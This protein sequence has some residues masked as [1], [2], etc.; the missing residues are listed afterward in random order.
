[1]NPDALMH[2]TDVLMEDVLDTAPEELFA[3]E[4]DDPTDWKK[5]SSRFD[6][7]LSKAKMDI[8]HSITEHGGTGRKFAHV[9]DATISAGLRKALFEEAS[10]D[11]GRRDGLGVK[12]LSTRWVWSSTRHRRT[13]CA[14][15]SQIRKRLDWVDLAFVTL[16]V[17][18]FIPVIYQWL[19]EPPGAAPKEESAHVA[20]IAVN[21]G[22]RA[23]S[24]LVRTPD[25]ATSSVVPSYYSSFREEM[26]LM[27]KAEAGKREVGAALAS[28]ASQERKVA[29]AALVIGNRDYEPDVD[30]VLRTTLNDARAVGEE[31]EKG[32]FHVEIAVNQ[33]RD[34]MQ[35]AIKAFNGKLQKGMTALIFFSGYGIQTNRRSYLIPIDADIW[36]EQEV[37][38]RGIGLDDI[39]AQMNETGADVKIAIIDAARR[40]PYE[41]RFRRGGGAQ[42]L[43]PV[44]APVG[45]LVLYSANAGS[46][47]G[48]VKES[49]VEHSLLV[50]E[51]LKE[52][53]GEGPS[54]GEV[55][56]RIRLGVSR[57]SSNEQTPSVLSS[58]SSTFSFHSCGKTVSPVAPPPVGDVPNPNP[59]VRVGPSLE[60]QRDFR[61]S[62]QS[63]SSD[64][65]LSPPRETPPVGS[66]T[67]ESTGTS[68]VP[69]R[70]TPIRV[71]ASSASA[72]MRE[73]RSLAD[74]HSRAKVAQGGGSASSDLGR[75]EA[76]A[77]THETWIIQVGG[78]DTEGAAQRRLLIAR[79]KVRYLLDKADPFT[80]PVM[81]GEKMLYR[82]RFAGFRDKEDAEEACRQ[83]KIKDVDCMTIS[84]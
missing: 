46:P 5:L 34:A 67:A 1:L 47:G 52:M 32:G 58:L 18:I 6:H 71:Q 61:P 59:Q 16:F 74:D 9:M 76:D 51:I 30:P 54:A 72:D 26:A 23:T 75:P 24:P 62:G 44:N 83:L 2:L 64:R 42:G 19:A 57:A 53:Q 73:G 78:F 68:I 40:N 79:S 37:Q 82:A 28:T 66:G 33:T 22:A 60:Q 45:S 11:D 12:L 80:E 25:R 27:R 43:A 39:L 17:A 65:L 10:N 49:G 84:Q 56:D 14:P 77:R 63:A 55:F 15:V 13:S 41:R 20:S 35:R 70:V 29:C 4:A 31:L 38:P 36:N 50:G 48:L 3:E 8:S 21:Q 7:I 81:K 69:K